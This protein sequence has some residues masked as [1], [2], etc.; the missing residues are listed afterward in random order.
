MRL[1]TYAPSQ[2][3]AGI[4][5]IFCSPP[6]S[7]P[8]MPSSAAI[9]A[10]DR[11]KVLAIICCSVAEAYW[12]ES[13]GLWCEGV[14]SL[15]D[16]SFFLSIFITSAAYWIGYIS[17]LTQLCAIPFLFQCIS[18][19]LIDL[20]DPKFSHVLMRHQ[21]SPRTTPLTTPPHGVVP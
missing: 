3:A 8:T 5:N 16:S 9:P 1:S 17:M 10:L 2:P 11:P 19:L 7:H 21:N 4:S 15:P 13:T 14:G 6:I 20:I 12:I 18:E